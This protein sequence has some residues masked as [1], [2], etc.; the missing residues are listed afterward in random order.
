MYCFDCAQE[1]RDSIG[2]I[3]VCTACGL[4]TCGEHAHITETDIRRPVDLGPHTSP[5]A[6]RRLICLTCRAAETAH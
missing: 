3:G 6:T 5:H 4:I 1:G 2:G